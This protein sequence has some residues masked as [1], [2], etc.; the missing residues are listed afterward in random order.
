MK[1]LNL[2]DLSVLL[3]E[4]SEMQLKLIQKHLND[5]GVCKV[6]SAGT[7]KA[8]LDEMRSYAP[9][10]V[11]S[12]MY[13]PDMTATDLL[14]AMRSDESLEAI[15]FMLIS[16]ETRFEQLDPIRQSGVVAILPKP[17]THDDLAHALRTTLE[18]IEPDEI[19]LDNYD[20]EDVRVLLVDDSAT[21]RRHVIRILNNLGIMQITQVENGRQAI[22]QLSQ[23]EFD[24][25][26]TDF[27][28]PEMDGQQ[29]IEHVRDVMGNSYIPILMV[30][31]E[32][33]QARLAHVQQAGVSAICDKPF[34]PASIRDV[35]Y[36]VLNEA[37]D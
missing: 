12:S 2:A 1:Y 24:L 11:I 37:T 26:V 21:A 29:L 28:M 31:S 8:A 25:I 17:F 36:R 10:L 23:Q 9:D 22:E 15:P 30:T 5:E 13:L 4:P 6:D 16:S 19:M 35:L 20:V 34:D 32:N 27:N 3:I 33:D 7:G 14:T 18:Y